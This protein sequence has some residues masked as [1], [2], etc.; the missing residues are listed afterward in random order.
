VGGNTPAA[1]N[2]ISG[3]DGDGVSI[4]GTSLGTERNKVQN[5]YIGTDKFGTGD[6]GNGGAGVS[7]FDSSGNAVG[8]GPAEANIIAFNA[9]DGVAVRSGN[10]IFPD[11]GNAIR[12]NSIFANGD[13]GID[14]RQDGPTANDPKDSDTGENDL[15]N[16]PVVTSAKT[17]G[18]KTTI[19]G[20][21]NSTPNKTFLIEF[22]SNPSGENEGKSSLGQKL[23]TT[24]ADGIAGFTFAPS[25]AVPVGQR[26][27]A[28]ATDSG[29]NTSEFSAPRAVVAS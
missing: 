22:F 6:L 17:G 12:F 27:T 13:L 26:I 5:N 4:F 10:N 29:R 24:N 9:L 1:R 3:N 19:K 2:L 28:T 21:L 25:Q 18:G 20:K 7:I 16:K 15:Q 11:S 14:L 23:V 8:G